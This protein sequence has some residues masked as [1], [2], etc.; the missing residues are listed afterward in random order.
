MRL[1]D[2]DVKP[3]LVLDDVSRIIAKFVNV[4]QGSLGASVLAGDN[5][6]SL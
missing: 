6:Q 4:D 1:V 2:N 5:R 3:R